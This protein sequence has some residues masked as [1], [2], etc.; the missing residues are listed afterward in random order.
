[1][2]ASSVLRRLLVLLAI[3]APFLPSS[4]A[5]ADPLTIWFVDPTFDDYSG[6]AILV[7]TPDGGNYVVDGGERD[8]PDWD[9]G[10]DRLAPLL[11]SL[12]I[13]A[14]DGM[15][16]THPHADHIGGLIYLL[17]HY[18]VASVWD[19]GLV[20]A[21]YTYEQYMDAVEA[22]GATYAVA[23]RGD[24]LDWGDSLTVEVLHPVDPLG[25]FSVN[26]TSIVIRVT[27]G[28]ISF[29]LTGDLE[30]ADGESEPEEA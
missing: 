10:R 25:Q 4:D 7:R 1:M 15:V 8:L 16:A 20:Y 23:R 17:Q 26:S 5:A 2:T 9:C 13:A 19:N 3:G 24:F 6:D 22:S 30:T 29:L 21:T 18:P 12:E 28:S 11:D 27:Y 14:L